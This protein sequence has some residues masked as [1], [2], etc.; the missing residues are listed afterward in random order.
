VE[1]YRFTKNDYVLQLYEDLREHRVSLLLKKEQTVLIEV[2]DKQIACVS[3]GIDDRDL[4]V[5]IKMALS[6]IE[7][8]KAYIRFL[9]RNEIIGH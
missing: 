1:K 2:F 6:D 7:E 4:Q 3:N 8:V 9:I 5:D